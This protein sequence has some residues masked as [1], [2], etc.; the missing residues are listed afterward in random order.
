P[1]CAVTYNPLGEASSRRREVRRKKTLR[2]VGTT[3]IPHAGN[4]FGTT[5]AAA[6]DGCAPSTQQAS[7]IS[8][9]TKWPSGSSKERS[10]RIV[11]QTKAAGRRKCWFAERVADVVHA[12]RAFVV[13]VDKTG[14]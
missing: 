9:S 10:G 7:S 12:G 14:Y 2:A 1:D 4:T 8:S 5:S 3:R 11:F 6:F 13:L